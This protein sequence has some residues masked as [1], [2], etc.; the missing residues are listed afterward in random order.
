MAHDRHCGHRKKRGTALRLKGVYKARS[1]VD[2][3]NFQ[4]MLNQFS[5][6]IIYSLHVNK[7]IPYQ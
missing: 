3:E 6:E 4:M 1:K 7:A 2:L 5:I